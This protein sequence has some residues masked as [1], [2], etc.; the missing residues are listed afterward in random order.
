MNE[1]ITENFFINLKV[2]EDKL[3]FGYIFSK[4]NEGKKEFKTMINSLK[5][6]N[7]AY[8]YFDHKEN[9]FY[10][11]NKR[12]IKDYKKWYSI[13]L[14]KNLYYPLKKMFPK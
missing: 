4:I 10:L 11:F 1:Y 13:H 7:I 12:K 6:S 9:T 2:K 3:Y 5:K 14:F 8:S